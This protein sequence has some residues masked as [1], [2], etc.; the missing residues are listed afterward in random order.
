MASF[1]IEEFVGEGVLK[2]LLPKLLEEGW[3]DVPTLKIM[4]TDDMDALSMTQLEKVGYLESFS[5]SVIFLQQML[6][7]TN[8]PLPLAHKYNFIVFFFSEITP[9]I[10]EHHVY[11]NMSYSLV[12]FYLSQKRITTYTYESA[13]KSFLLCVL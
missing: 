13:S 11:K 8:L 3:D 7:K 6:S 10:S 9:L 5:S 2:V 12:C 1:S 4:N